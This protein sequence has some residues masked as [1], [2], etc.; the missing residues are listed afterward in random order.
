M[1]TRLIIGGFVLVGVTALVT[2]QVVSQDKGGEK[3]KMPDTGSE[4]DQMMKVYEKAAEPGPNHK[5]LAVLAGNWN[6]VVRPAAGGGETPAET[7][8]TIQRKWILGGRYLQENYDGQLMNKPFSGMGIFGYDN[9]NQR[10]ECLWIDTMMTGFLTLTGDWDTT[11]KALTF[12]GTYDDPVTKAPRKMKMVFRIES[13]SKNT[14]EMYD[15]LPDGKEMKTME[16]VA[17]RQ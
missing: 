7:K 15:F 14:F 17:T 12:T 1:K 5:R 10:Y 11:G 13:E 2:Q 3:P 16:I 6:C 8:G 9:I 4:M